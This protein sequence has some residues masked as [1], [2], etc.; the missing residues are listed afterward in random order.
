MPDNVVGKTNHL[1]ACAFGHLGESFGLC[2]VFKGIRR[3]VD[4]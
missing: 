3:E 2:L 4:T 1:V